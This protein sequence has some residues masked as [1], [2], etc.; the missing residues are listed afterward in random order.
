MVSLDRPHPASVVPPGCC[1]RGVEGGGL[2]LLAACLLWALQSLRREP[3]LSRDPAFMSQA[4][5]PVGF[6]EKR[7]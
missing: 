7:S 2:L 6:V 5:N 1:G 3:H 4:A